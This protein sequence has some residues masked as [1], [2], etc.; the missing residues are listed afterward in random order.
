MERDCFV[1]ERIASD[2]SQIATK[3]LAHPT[4][5]S[6]GESQVKQVQ[7]VVGGRLAKAAFL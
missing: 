1:D 2:M 3:P 7:I 5:S 4:A 6:V